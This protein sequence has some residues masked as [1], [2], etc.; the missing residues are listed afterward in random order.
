MGLEGAMT[1][2]D[3]TAF[4]HMGYSNQPAGSEETVIA[5][6]DQGFTFFDVV[7]ARLTTS[8][9]R[10]EDAPRRRRSSRFLAGHRH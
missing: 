6:S 3:G 8:T 1:L 2:A 5:T 9:I 7:P 10:P 4:A